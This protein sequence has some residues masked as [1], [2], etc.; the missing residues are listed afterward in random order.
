MILIRNYSTVTA[1]IFVLN[2][3]VDFVPL[4]LE[5]FLAEISI[6]FFIDFFKSL[7]HAI[8]IALLIKMGK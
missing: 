7:I 6:H 5:T 3:L 8:I 1:P 2:N 4:N